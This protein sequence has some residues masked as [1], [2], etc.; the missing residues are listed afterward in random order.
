MTTTTGGFRERARHAYAAQLEQ[1]QANDAQRRRDHAA[2]LERE[3]RTRMAQA[4]A[5]PDGEIRFHENHAG[6]PDYTFAW[7]DGLLFAYGHELGYGNRDVF[8]VAL[9]CGACGEQPAATAVEWLD[10]PHHLYLDR[11][12]A[13]LARVDGGTHNRPLCL[14]CIRNLNRENDEAMALDL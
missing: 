8:V 1:E 13:W 2:R 11:I 3:V 7:C 14:D 10:V 12:G 4:G 6:W 5:E 9:P